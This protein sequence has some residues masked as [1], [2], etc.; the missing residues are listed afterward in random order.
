MLQAKFWAMVVNCLQNMHMQKV[1]HIGIAVKS[2]SVSIP[3]FE[4]LLNTPCY[5]TEL[6][7]T[8]QVNTA[9][10]KQGET[11]IE[12]LESIDPDGVIARFIEKKGEGM[13]HIAFDVDD[14]EA[15][16]KRLQQEG[17]VLLSEQPKSG[18]D[19]K[20]VCFLH[21]KSTNGVLIEL[22]QEKK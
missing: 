19:N 1:E 12:L 2:L 14:I 9:F 13:H 6:V 22:C 3:L 4:K 10:F 16:M 5:K 20:L 8:E 21:P 18:A 15:E 17:F 11:K 7:E